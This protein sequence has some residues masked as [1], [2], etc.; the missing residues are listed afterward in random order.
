MTLAVVFGAV[1][2]L[3]CVGL[4][5]GLRL[6][7]TP[8]DVVA[9]RVERPLGPGSQ[10]GGTEGIPVRAGRAVAARIEGAG[11]LTGPTRALMAPYLAITGQTTERL[12]AQMLVLSGAGLLAPPVLWAVSQ[13]AGVTTPF[14]APIL[15][16]LV[17]VAGGLAFPVLQMVAD[18]RRR[19]HHFRVV[20]GSFVDLV[21]LSLAAGVGIEGA[22]FS[23]SKVS[24]D[25]AARRMARALL[26]ARDG[27]MPPWVALGQLGDELGV[28]E[29]VELSTTLQLAGT[30]GTRIRQSLNARA[31]SIRRH[32]QADAES[33]ANAMTE[34]LFL[35]GALLLV[36]FLLFVGYPAFNRILGGF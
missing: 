9:A 1:T 14:G 4:L 6:R 28:P 18:A 23:A 5:R 17:G 34:R 21:V 15:L 33:A 3:G 11:M 25:W 31:A 8:L 30:E 16:A 19:R 20:I 32:E 35:P 29:L 7:P 36:G 22:L 24:T 27:G 12:V 2:G 13:L 10:P 26:K